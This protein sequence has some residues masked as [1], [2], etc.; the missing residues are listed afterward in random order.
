MIEGMPAITITLLDPEAGRARDLV[1]HQR[2]AVRDA[3]HAHAR[4]VELAADLGHA[5]LQ[6][7]RPLP[8]D[9]SSGTPNALATHSAVMSSCVGPMPPVVNT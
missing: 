4:L 2:G 5:F 9:D 1:L 8:G 3:R 7:A 6:D